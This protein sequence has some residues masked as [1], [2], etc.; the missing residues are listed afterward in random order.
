GQ[1][2]VFGL[3]TVAAALAERAAQQDQQQ[4]GGDQQREHAERQQPL[5]A[6]GYRDLQRGHF[7]LCFEQ[8]DLLFLRAQVELHL[9][10]GQAALAGDAVGCLRRGNGAVQVRERGGRLPPPFGQFREQA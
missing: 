3:P 9:E 7:L 2:V 5:P 6:L 1:A 10:I 4:D 8:G